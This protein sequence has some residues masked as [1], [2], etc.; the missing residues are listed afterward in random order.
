MQQLVLCDFFFNIF[1]VHHVS[2]F[3]VCLAAATWYCWKAFLREHAESLN[4]GR[5]LLYVARC[6]K[7]KLNMCYIVHAIPSWLS[8]GR[9]DRVCLGALA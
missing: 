6:Q 7:E 8:S 4:D 5:E 2:V 9:R 3:F 1:S